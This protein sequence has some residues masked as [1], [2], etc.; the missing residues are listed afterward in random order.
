MKDIA[1]IVIPVG[2]AN[3]KLLYTN[4]NSEIH[5][6]AQSQGW[7]NYT[8]EYFGPPQNNF[9]F[10]E[11][12]HFGFAVEIGGVRIKKKHLKKIATFEEY[13]YLHEEI[14]G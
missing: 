13:S 2:G 4:V 9:S 8:V 7:K 14:Y 3:G 5:K 10:N 12:I 11:L 1:E 6:Y